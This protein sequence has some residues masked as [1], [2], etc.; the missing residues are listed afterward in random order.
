MGRDCERE[1][2]AKE[3]GLQ[4]KAE[5]PFIDRLSDPI[6]N[7]RRSP[8]RFAGLIPQ[9][10]DRKTVYFYLVKSLVVNV[11]NKIGKLKRA[12]TEVKE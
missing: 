9:P 3:K 4:K 1:E 11:I 7:V 12:E 10:G 6:H 8:Y 5:P 2:T